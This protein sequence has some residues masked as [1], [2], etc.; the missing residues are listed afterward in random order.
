MTAVTQTGSI[1]S[2]STRRSHVAVRTLTVAGFALP[3]ALYFWLIHQYALDI[4]YS[5]QWHD[6]QLLGQSYSGTL[7][8]HSLWAQYDENRNFFP[9]LIVLL[10]GHTDHFNVVSEEYLSALMSL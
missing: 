5:D 7:T 2:S 3:V 10:L 6:I 4:V 9:N 8:F 1:S